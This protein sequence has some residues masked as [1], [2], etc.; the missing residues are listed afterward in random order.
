MES[1][2]LDTKVNKYKPATISCACTYIVMKFFK[3]ENYHEAYDKK[4]FLIDE[5]KEITLEYNIQ[6]NYSVILC[7]NQQSLK[8]QP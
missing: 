7:L 4:F 2:L 8:I 1:F 5:K 6:K 3:M